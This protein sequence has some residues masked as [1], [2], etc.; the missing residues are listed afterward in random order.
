M[1]YFSLFSCGRQYAGG[2]HYQDD[3]LDDGSDRVGGDEH[4]QW[5]GGGEVSG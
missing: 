2:A 4:A 1:I 5:L 3:W